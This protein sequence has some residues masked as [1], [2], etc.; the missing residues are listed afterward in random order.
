MLE[1]RHLRS[2]SVHLTSHLKANLGHF[3]VKI[4]MR[5]CFLCCSR[6]LLSMSCRMSLY[7]LH[8]LI[9]HFGC[10]HSFSEILIQ[11]VL[12]VTFFLTI[13]TVLPEI[14]KDI[15]ILHKPH[16]QCC[17]YFLFPQLLIWVAAFPKPC[18]QMFKR[19]FL[20]WLFLPVTITK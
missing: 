13:N 7:T 3:D 18:D 4:F 10:P 17:N 6:A 20:F 1:N 12:T 15:F 11:N 2:L 8:F 19:K 16:D 5:S 9:F 14:L